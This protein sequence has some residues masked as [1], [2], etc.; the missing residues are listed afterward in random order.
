MEYQKIINLLDNTTNQ[1]SK[2]RKR[3]LVEMNDESEGRYD[4]SKIIFKTFMI[5]SDLCNYG[6]VQILAKGTITVPDTTDAGAA[7]NNTNK[8]VI[9]KICPPFTDCITQINN[10]KVDN[11]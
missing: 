7:L 9:F 10:T 6:D 3:N 11:A 5:G 4:F 1:P 8:K 2:S